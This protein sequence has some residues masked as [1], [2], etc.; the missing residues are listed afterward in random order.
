MAD[1][2]DKQV[3]V[4]DQIIAELKSEYG[5]KMSAT[6]PYKS[7]FSPDLKI[8]ATDFAFN[9]ASGV[10]AISA[11]CQSP[12]GDNWKTER[13]FHITNDDVIQLASIAPKFKERFSGFARDM[14]ARLESD[15]EASRLAVEAWSNSGL[16]SAT[17][18]S[19]MKPLT[20]KRSI[21]PAS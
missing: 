10:I 4:V 18:I 2:E 21:K 16:P 8:T 3:S 17:P 1:T 20:L 11:D 14:S 15:R 6:R 12:Y 13:T 7:L 19:A 9:R 5:D